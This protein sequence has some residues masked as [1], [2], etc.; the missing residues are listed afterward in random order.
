MFNVDDYIIYGADSVCKVIANNVDNI[1]LK[2]KE[3]K[4]Y[5]LEPLFEN[6]SVIYT[7]ID[8]DKVTMRKIISKEEVSTLISN[9]AVLETYNF[10]DKLREE[11]Y[12]RVMHKHDCKEL[13]GVL[14]TYYKIKRERLAEN[15]NVIAIDKK[16]SKIIEEWLS[17]EFSVSLGITKEEAKEMIDKKIRETYIK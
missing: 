11:V 16:N 4:Y 7:P 1:N 15:K 10:D 5:K 9:I 14:K 8:N 6:K 2:Y 3:K 17:E 13:I 12:K